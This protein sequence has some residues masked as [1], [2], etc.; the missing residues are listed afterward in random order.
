MN[1]RN[2]IKVIGTERMLLRPLKRK[3]A[4]FIFELMNSREWKE[5]IGER[6]IKN[7]EDA[8]KTINL[9]PFRSYREN[10]FGLMGMQLR[11][12]DEVLIGLCGLLQRPYLDAPDLGFA[13]LPQY[14]G[15][16]FAFEACQAIIEDLKK[17]NRFKRIV[18]FT[19]HHNFR[20]QRL[21]LKLGFEMLRLFHPPG[22]NEEVSLFELGWA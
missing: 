13:L 7:L 20:S 8:V 15:K 22:E 4:A 5:F 18:A 17:E 3:D 14:A 21:L 10:G 1:Q 12:K 11:D 9:G 19:D 16:G 6:G 2:K